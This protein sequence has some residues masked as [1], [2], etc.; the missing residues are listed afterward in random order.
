MNPLSSVPARQI[1][2]EDAISRHKTGVSP[3]RSKQKI[4][5]RYGHLNLASNA[6]LLA[7]TLTGYFAFN[8]TYTG[9]N[10]YLLSLAGSIFIAS[11]FFYLRNDYRHYAR[12]SLG[13]EEKNFNDYVHF[14]RY[15][16][17][18]PINYFEEDA[19]KQ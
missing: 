12:E 7:V 1:F 17:I 13:C 5:M 11:F 10:V 14:Y 9:R 3:I 15:A 2:L 4:A 18:D 8:K 16:N 6:S 19:R